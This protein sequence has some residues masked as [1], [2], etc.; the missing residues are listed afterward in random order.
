MNSPFKSLRIVSAEIDLRSVCLP[1]TRG[2]QCGR[3]KSPMRFDSDEERD[4]AF[5]ILSW[6]FSDIDLRKMGLRGGSDLKECDTAGCDENVMLSST[7]GGS[8]SHFIRLLCIGLLTGGSG[9][10]NAPVVILLIG[11]ILPLRFW[12]HWRSGVVISDVIVLVF[13]LLKSVF[14]T[15]SFILRHFR[16]LESSLLFSGVFEVLLMSLQMSELRS[17]GICVSPSRLSRSISSIKS[18]SVVSH[19]PDES[20]RKLRPDEFIVLDSTNFDGVFCM[21]G[22]DEVDGR[23][24]T[25]NLNA[26][27][28][29]LLKPW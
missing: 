6:S 17:P 19:E 25:G 3:V 13:G 12:R 9:R 28:L 2:R 22:G 11:V 15:F 4:S 8:F 5:L 18:S 20:T 23:L 29:L 27:N 14:L 16:A 24:G 21:E 10:L 26:V 7:F 1:S